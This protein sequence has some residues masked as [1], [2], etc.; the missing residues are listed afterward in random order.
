MYDESYYK[1][2]YGVDRVRRFD[3]HWWSN[4]FYARLSIKYLK[5]IGG[6][7]FLD[8]GCAH[9]YL[10]QQLQ[11]RCE[12]YG[13]D[14]SPY[15]VE[16]SK[17]ISPR[18][19][20]RVGDLEGDLVGQFGAGF[21]D[22]VLAKYVLEHLH[23]PASVIEQCHGLL[24]DGGIL[25][26]SVPNPDS[27]LKEM[28][29]DQWIGS[30]DKTHISV[31]EPG[32]WYRI[33]KGHGFEVIKAFSDGFWDVPYLPVIPAMFQFPFFGFLTVIEVLTAIPFIPVPWG[34]NLIVIAQKR[35]KIGE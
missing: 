13:I 19:H 20:T 21:F 27:L 34:E 15:A 12:A 7:R 30:R 2:E 3:M 26:F 28:K 35:A 8:I 23:D 24:R 6:R 16:R 11:N 1:S 4:S 9:G 32:K 29:G 22:L 25:I 33:T 5:R 10:L 31:Y 17:E 18:A 14:L